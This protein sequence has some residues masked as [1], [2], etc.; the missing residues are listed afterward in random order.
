MCSNNGAEF[1]RR[2]HLAAENPTPLISVS[3]VMTLFYL[4][5]IARNLSSRWIFTTSHHLF[6]FQ[7]VSRFL[8]RNHIEIS[9]NVT[10]GDDSLAS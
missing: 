7:F 5:F 3:T 10:A 6:L 1:Q 2:L 4:N 8:P 9:L